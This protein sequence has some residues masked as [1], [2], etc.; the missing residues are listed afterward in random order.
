MRFLHLGD[1]HFGKVI[2]SFSMIEDQQYVLEQ[3]KQYIETYQPDAVL[4]A[5]DIYDRSVPPAVAVSLYSRF[6]KE[7]LIDLKTPILAVAGNHDGADLVNFGSELFESANYYV[8]GHYT[9]EV[10]KV[11]L[12]DEHGL[13]NFYLIPF[14]DYAVVREVHQDD[15]IK[16]LDAAMKMTLEKLDLNRKE[17]NVLI[18]HAFV[19]GGDEEPQ[20]CESEKK[21]VVGGKESVSASY[22]DDFDYVALGHLHR[23]QKV[24]NDNI[25][26]SGS[27]LKYSFSEED[28]HK[29]VTMVD[30]D[31][32]GAITYEL[33]P[34]IPRRDMR[35]IKGELNELL[36]QPSSEDYLRVIL[37]DRGELLEPMAKL[38]KVYPNIMILE[39][40][41][42]F[43]EFK[44]S[45]LD[46]FTREQKT[47]EQLFSD[48]YLHHK[49]NT[50]HEEGTQLIQKI[51][52]QVREEI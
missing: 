11:V 36:N 10:K 26:Y 25:R 34:L 49:G 38:R 17:R 6:L 42:K 47:P 1:L 33:L 21:L 51:I 45:K 12:K 37:T 2:H 19:V 22:F 7:V 39:L 48:F 8:A 18:T 3:V 23:T 50:L 35:T 43:N 30:L 46:K 24:G 52:H 44:G 32:S 5:G 31:E 16:S 29:S 28:Y 14:A 15:N 40:D 27:L 20:A 13:V 41:Q 9:K 4:L